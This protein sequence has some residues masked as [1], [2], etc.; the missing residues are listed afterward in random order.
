VPVHRLPGDHRGGAARG[1]GRPLKTHPLVLDTDIGSDVDDALALAYAVRHPELQLRA[2]T[3]VSGDATKRAHIAA[4]LLAIEGRDDVV[5]AAGVDGP[6]DRTWSGHEGEGLDAGPELRLDERSAIE[7]LLADAA[8]SDPAV[9]STIGTQGNVAATVQ[10]DPGYASRVP[11]LAVM[12]GVFA[13][14]D[15]FGT[16]LPASRDY[17]LV[18]DGGASVVSLNAGF[19]TLYVPIDVTFRTTLRERHLDRLRAGDALC[20]ALAALCD[21]WRVVLH[22]RGEARIPADVVSFLH[23]PLTVACVAS[24][25]FVTVETRNVRVVA[26]E[27]VPRTVVD[28]DRGVPAEVVTDVDPAAFVEHW[29]D[30]VIG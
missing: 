7:V 23:D 4:R 25:A 29:C 5:V 10:R 1:R 21:V 14:I 30:V 11:L 2:V 3:T 28:D 24:R 16:S 9:V 19:R 27:G 6:M 15:L 12:G 13:P 17:N 8:G 18:A 20:R 22:G 26:I